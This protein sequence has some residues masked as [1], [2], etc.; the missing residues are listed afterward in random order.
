MANGVWA[1]PNYWGSM[2]SCLSIAP[3][4]VYLL[5]EIGCIK[6]G[7]GCGLWSTGP[8]RQRSAHPATCLGQS[9][10][11]ASQGTVLR[12]VTVVTDNVEPARPTRTC[13]N[14]CRTTQGEPSYC[15]SVRLPFRYF[16]DTRCFQSCY[17]YAS[18]MR[19]ARCYIEIRTFPPLTYS[20]LSLFHHHHPPVYNAKRSTVNVYKIVSGRSV[21]VRSIG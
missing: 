13:R 19:R 10:Q 12:H 7:R 8:G 16:T 9:S 20:S 11:D 2:P 6:W 4:Q 15:T 17:G 5:G 1:C 18:I 21:R 14:S 3:C